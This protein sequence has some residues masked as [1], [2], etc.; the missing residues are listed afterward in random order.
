MSVYIELITQT[1]GHYYFMFY[2]RYSLFLPDPNASFA[3]YV[4]T[5]FSICEKLNIF[6][7]IGLIGQFSSARWW[8]NEHVPSFAFSH[9]GRSCFYTLL[10]EKQTLNGWST[11]SLASPTHPHSTKK[12]G[13]RERKMLKFIRSF[14]DFNR[15]KSFRDFK[16]PFICFSIPFH[17][18]FLFCCSP[19]WLF[20]LKIIITFGHLYNDRLD[21]TIRI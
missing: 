20:F 11:Y 16:S 18:F 13:E 1:Y 5:F 7:S 2:V 3:Q 21:W 8:A 4:N 6:L 9:N 19:F 12:E 10:F 17:R 15:F 14:N